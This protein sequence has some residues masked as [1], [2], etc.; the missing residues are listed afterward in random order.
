MAG[1]RPAIFVFG[2]GRGL[3]SSGGLIPAIGYSGARNIL[4]N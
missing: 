1:R 3:L 4:A 2:T